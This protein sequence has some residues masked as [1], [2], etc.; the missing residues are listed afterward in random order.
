MQDNVNYVAI[1]RETCRSPRCRVLGLTPWASHATLHSTPHQKKRIECI[2]P[3]CIAKCN[4]NAN[5]LQKTLELPK[6]ENT[7]SIRQYFTFTIHF[8]YICKVS[9]FN[10][11]W[12]YIWLL[13]IIYNV[14]FQTIRFNDGW[15]VI[16][17]WV[18]A[19]ICRVFE[20]N[21]GFHGKQLNNVLLPFAD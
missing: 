1:R 4:L 7:I 2:F 19:T 15:L 20:I 8:F 9:L 14:T 11:E 17:N 6:E 16:A 21:W 13:W 10:C 18:V 3:D 12:L 5:T